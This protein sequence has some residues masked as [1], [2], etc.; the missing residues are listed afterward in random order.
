MRDAFERVH[1][2]G[3][4]TLLGAPL[5]AAAVVLETALSTAGIQAILIAVVLAGAGPVLSHATLR[6][7]RIGERGDWRPQPDEAIEEA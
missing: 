6:A 7:I 1:Y 3:P 2:L 4:A 5:I